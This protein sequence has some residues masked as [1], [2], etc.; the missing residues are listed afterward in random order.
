[1][2]V[3]AF[4]DHWGIR[5]NPFQAEEARHD[6]VFAR[7]GIEQT[8][9]PDFHKILGDP[10][11]P[12]AAIVFGEKGSGKTAIR[13]QL[14]TRVSEHNQAHP[15]ARVL[16]VAY[17]DLNP[18]L[19]RLHAHATA[20]LRPGRGIRRRKSESESD[21]ILMGLQRVRLADHMDA[22]L[23]LATASLMDRLLAEAPRPGAPEPA[24][25][26]HRKL[27]HVLKRLDRQAK[28]DLTLLQAIYDRD[29]GREAQR[30]ALLRRR[31]RGST[32][33]HPLLWRTL[34]L[35]GWLP[36]AGIVAA[37]FFV[38][39]QLVSPPMW[40]WAGG[41]TGALWLLLLLKHVVIDRWRMSRLARRITKQ[42]RAVPR[43]QEALAASLN[44]VPP[45][46]RAPG[47]LPLEDAEESRYAMFTRLGRAMGALGYA[48]LLVVV[49][50]VD[51]PTL[52]RGDPD[53]MK[54]VIWPML[55][56]KFLQQPGVGVK[57][58]L[59]IEL[60]HELFR[61]SQSFFQGA[62]LDKQN[63]IERL[64]WTG[65][66]LYDLCNAR[67]HACAAP[68]RTAPLTLAELFA[69][70]VSRQDLVDSLDQMHQP[71]DAFK[72]LYQCICEHCAKGTLD[73]SEA[74]ENWRISR[75]VLEMV[76]KQQVER[77]Q[78]VYR[79]VRPA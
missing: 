9:H 65:P 51:E 71:R 74:E 5:E 61:E 36:L 33:W 6:P 25:A 7:L 52:V 13:M 1:M 37:N 58:L 27:R 4:L 24:L 12:S 55:N 39:P 63:M 15:D 41:V 69:P 56:N 49:D 70:D 66:A 42:V 26:E 38:D 14:E 64:A 67:L 77:V 48:G 43:S 23:H 18:I 79:G 59:P 60:R 75:D 16:L 73:R 34:A 29:T 76:R 57:M 2:N 35:L 44:I 50:R 68:G 17:D 10:A 19:D 28:V 53:R 54:A 47:D 32:N 30:T 40:I 46:I 78:G 72:L 31:L 20:R 62:R 21:T 11:R 45:A 8:S 3:A 22:V